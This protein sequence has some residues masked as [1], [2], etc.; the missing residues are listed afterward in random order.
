MGWRAIMLWIKIRWGDYERML[1]DPETETMHDKYREKAR[2][3]ARANQ[4][5]RTGMRQTGMQGLKDA[6][7]H[8]FIC[9]AL[10]CCNYWQELREESGERARYKG[11]DLPV[12]LR[13]WDPDNSSA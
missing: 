5:D 6:F 8:I 2:A 13:N 4:K 7:R 1:M 10:A 12:W 9:T 11:D 3:Y